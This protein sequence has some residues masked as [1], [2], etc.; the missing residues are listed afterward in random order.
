MIE[1]NKK[2]W[3]KPELTILCESEINDNLLG[4]PTPKRMIKEYI[5]YEKN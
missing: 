4:S 5:P 2:E 1:N 3:I